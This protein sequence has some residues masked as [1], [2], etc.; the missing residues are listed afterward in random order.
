MQDFAYLW[1]I[2]IEVAS[3][4]LKLHYFG[5]YYCDHIPATFIFKLM[6]QPSCPSRMGQTR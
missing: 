2:G 3:T 6:C 4:R 5:T 1:I